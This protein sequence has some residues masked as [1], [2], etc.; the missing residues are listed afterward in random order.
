MIF[1]VIEPSQTHGPNMDPANF[2]TCLFTGPCQFPK[3][4]RVHCENGPVSRCSVDLLYYHL[5]T[6]H[7]NCYHEFFFVYSYSCH[8]CYIFSFY[9]L[10]DLIDVE[11]E[12]GI[13]WN[14][15]IYIYICVCVCV[16]ER[17]L[18]TYIFMANVSKQFY[19]IF[20]QELNKL[21]NFITVF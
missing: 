15:Y 6:H 2:G 11:G 8:W 13:M 21:S 14:I 7:H 16:W 3:F 4:G 20:Y 18:L 5:W 17:V 19:E 1:Y 9:W 12:K 10:Y